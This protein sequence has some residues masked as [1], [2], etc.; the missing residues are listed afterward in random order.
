MDK[1]IWMH[2]HPYTNARA[3]CLALRH[4]CLEIVFTHKYTLSSYAKL[5]S[6]N[7]THISSTSSSY[8]CCL[9]PL[10]PPFRFSTVNTNR[11]EQSINQTTICKDGAWISCIINGRMSSLCVNRLCCCAVMLCVKL[12]KKVAELGSLGLS[13]FSGCRFKRKLHTLYCM[14]AETPH[15]HHRHNLYAF[16]GC[17]RRYLWKHG[18]IW[19]V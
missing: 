14:Q 4:I 19:W 1:R 13:S 12:K 7:R 8:V 15:I 18:V 10:H 5:K 11:T 9:L 17:R 2:T 6:A 3:S 16:G